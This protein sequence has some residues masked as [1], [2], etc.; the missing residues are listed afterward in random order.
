MAKKSKRYREI[1]E[2][3]AQK[4]YTIDDALTLIKEQRSAKFDESV[5]VHIALGINPKK[6]E[7]IIR[8]IIHLPHGTGKKIKVAVFT[9]SKAE[10]AKSAGADII[11]GKELVEEV[12]KTKTINCTSAIATP[13]FM[14]HLAKIAKILGPKGIMPS[15]KTGTVT[16]HIADTIK[17]LKKGQVN[18]KNDAGGNLHQ[19]IGKVS[20]DAQNIKEN[21]NAF[22][23]E[24]KRL[25]PRGVKGAYIRGITLCTTMG[26]GI[27]I[28][29]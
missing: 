15:P 9:E 23:F 21:F 8:S 11:G 25:K 26:A 3:M 20:W 22:L 13:D 29:D 4:S 28:R 16:E 6:S 14:Q 10:E 17:K 5:E 24:V 7:Q 2:K 19:I 27:K 12:A 1:G 18:L